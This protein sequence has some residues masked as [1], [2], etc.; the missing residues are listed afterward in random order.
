MKLNFIIDL[1]HEISLSC[2]G[3]AGCLPCGLCL[4]FQNLPVR[5][6]VEKLS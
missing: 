3:Y 4:G 1:S 2:M 6:Y 5:V